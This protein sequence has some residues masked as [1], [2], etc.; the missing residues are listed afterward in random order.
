MG[1]EAQNQSDIPT[2]HSSKKSFTRPQLHTL[3][4][5]HWLIILI[6]I[7]LKSL[8]ERKWLIISEMIF[9]IQ[10]IKMCHVDIYLCSFCMFVLLSIF[11][12]SYI[13]HCIFKSAQSMQRVHHN[14]HAQNMNIF[15]RVF[16]YNFHR[17]IFLFLLERIIH[18]K[19]Q[20][21]IKSFSIKVR[22]TNSQ[23]GKNIKQI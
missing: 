11:I 13:F 23:C 8:Y 5:C 10:V 22:G 1:I 18:K 21:N 20:V 9:G 17:K 7:R 19:K 3:T 14:A 16:L 4:L 15:C 2:C 12:D 6:I